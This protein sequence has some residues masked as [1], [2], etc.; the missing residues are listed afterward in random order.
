MNNISLFINLEKLNLFC[1]KITKIEDLD[2][3]VNL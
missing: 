1:N 2:K 3:L